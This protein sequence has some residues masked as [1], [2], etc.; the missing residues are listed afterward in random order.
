MASKL[1]SSHLLHQFVGLRR[2]DLREIEVQR[3]FMGIARHSFAALVKR[4]KIPGK[5]G[6]IDY[7][8]RILEEVTESLFT[9]CQCFLSS[10]ALADV[11]QG[12]ANTNK[13]PARI[14]EHLIVK[15]DGHKSPVL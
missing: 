1:A 3:F 13:S 5:I 7:V 15:L 6:R 4:S 10:L 8:T 9:L 12:C 2:D 14:M 11:L